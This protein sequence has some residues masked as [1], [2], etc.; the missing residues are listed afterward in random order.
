MHPNT[1]G[2]EKWKFSGEGL[3]WEDEYE[4]RTNPPNDTDNF[5]DVRDKNSHEEGDADP[6]YRQ[7]QAGVHLV[8]FC[9][10]VALASQI[11]QRVLNHR[12]LRGGGG[13]M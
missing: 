12:P 2:E 3:T 13:A 9:Y 6:S 4:E 7:H 8:W 1:G 10:N 11:Q 5:T